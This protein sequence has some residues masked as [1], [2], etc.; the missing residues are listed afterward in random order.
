[1]NLPFDLIANAPGFKL[2]AGVDP[3]GLT[4]TQGFVGVAFADTY[5][6][7]VPAAVARHRGGFDFEEIATLKELTEKS[8]FA[9]QASYKGFSYSVA[10]KI[11]R[12]R[13]TSLNDR[14]IRTY[15]YSKYE[16]SVLEAPYDATLA[17]D[18]FKPDVIAMRAELDTAL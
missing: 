5:V 3:D 15:A 12:E 6:A 9:V 4:S 14:S 7:G 10:A 8:A 2:L 11:N 17:S 16:T 13:E 1:M 18:S